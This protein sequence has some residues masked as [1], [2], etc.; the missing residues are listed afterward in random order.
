MP[1]VNNDIPNPLLTALNEP[2]SIV[3]L[4]K[5]YVRNPLAAINLDALSNEKRQDLLVQRQNFLVP[6]T[7]TTQITRRLHRLIRDSYAIRNPTDIKNRAQLQL[8]AAT[9]GQDDAMVLP[10]SCYAGGMLVEGIT[11]LMKSFTVAR[12]LELLGPQLV[13]HKENPAAGWKAWTQIVYLIVPASTTG[14]VTGFLQNILQALD[15]L[16]GTNYAKQY[17][18][19]VVDRLIKRV[20]LLLAVRFTGVL[21][22]EEIQL[23]SLGKDTTMFSLFVLTIMNFGIPVCLVGNPL[24]M[25]KLRQYSQDTRRFSL[26]GSISLLPFMSQT[27]L[28]FRSFTSEIFSFSVM[29]KRRKLTESDFGQIFQFTGGIPE[30]ISRLNAEAQL[31]ALSDGADQVTPEDRAA[32]FEGE[33]F[34]DNHPLIHGLAR[35][36]VKF[37]LHLEDIPAA[38][39]KSIWERE[40]QLSGKGNED[41]RW[42]SLSEVEA[43]ATSRSAKSKVEATE[44]RLRE[45]MKREKGKEKLD[46]ELKK[47]LPKDDFRVGG[48]VFAYVDALS[49]LEDQIE[50]KRRQ[51]LS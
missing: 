1:K 14:G 17:S 43:S 46:E 32:A 37:L 7:A 16:L 51:S 44:R 28:E 18:R 29:P 47:A 42:Q 27:D 30:F 4:P 26:G 31:N 35:R 24:A 49:E 10:A 34:R 11:G 21:V 40:Q 5:N 15:G 13:T 39:F 33:T 50:Q 48:G 6:T 38:F 12:A 36:D 3:D 45:K 20:A 23:K 9:A 22:I 8:L 2:I 41:P 25:E 19:H